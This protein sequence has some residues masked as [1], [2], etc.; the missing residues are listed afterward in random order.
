M[1]RKTAL[2]IVIFTEKFFRRNLIQK[3][4]FNNYEKKSQPVIYIF[5]DCKYWLFTDRQTNQKPD[6]DD[7]GWNFAIRSFSIALG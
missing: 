6:C 3:R 5:I 1:I 7:S 2:P 4:Y